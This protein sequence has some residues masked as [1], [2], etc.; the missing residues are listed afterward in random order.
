MPAT[1]TPT[2]LNARYSASSLA[3][4]S[5]PSNYDLV[6]IVNSGDSSASSPAST[7]TV[8]VS[9]T[10]QV[11]LLPG[12]GT[13]TGRNTLW[14][15]FYAIN[16]PD[17]SSLAAFFAS[18]FGPNPQQL[19]VIQVLSPNGGAVVWHLDYLGVAYTP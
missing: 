16:T 8:R 4:Y 10:G 9:S 15:R 12:K 11:I 17:T 7:I 6:Q 2:A 18:A 5:N 1:A 13:S 14:G 3:A 19:D